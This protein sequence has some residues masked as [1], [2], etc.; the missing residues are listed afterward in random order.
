M[1]VEKKWKEQMD[2]APPVCDER[3]PENSKTYYYYEAVQSK[4]EEGVSSQFINYITFVPVDRIGQSIPQ[5]LRLGQTI[6][7]NIEF[8]SSDPKCDA[9]KQK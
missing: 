9:S 4:R 3:L 5:N 2:L 8:K 7:Y 6:L 1:F